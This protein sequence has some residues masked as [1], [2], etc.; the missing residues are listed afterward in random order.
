MSKLIFTGKQ[1]DAAIKK[2]QEGYADVSKVTAKPEQVR[3]GKRYVSKNKVLETGTL[4]DGSMVSNVTVPS[5][6]YLSRNETEY[7]VVFTPGGTVTRAGYKEKGDIPGAASH[8]VYIQAEEKTV[9]GTS[10]T[11]EV[12][13]SEG[14]L[15]KKVTIKKV[16]GEESGYLER[17]GMQGLACY[18]YT[19]AASSSTR[20]AYIPAGT[21]VDN[22]YLKA[23]VKTSDA[24]VVIFKI[25]G[26]TSSSYK[27]GTGYLIN[28]QSGLLNT[29]HI[30]LKPGT[31]YTIPANDTYY[32][33]GATIEYK[34]TGRLVITFNTDYRVFSRS[35]STSTAND[36]TMPLLFCFNSGYYIILIDSTQWTNGSK[37]YGSATTNIAGIYPSDSDIYVNSGST[38]RTF[39]Q[40]ETYMANVSC[41]LAA[42]SFSGSSLTSPL[43]LKVGKPSSMFYMIENARLP[44][45]VVAMDGDYVTWGA[46]DEATSYD[47]TATGNGTTVTKNTSALRYSM[48]SLVTND[49]TYEITVT[50]KKSGLISNPSEPITYTLER[51]LGTP[52]IHQEGEK[53]YIDEAITD[54]TTYYLYVNGTKIANLSYTASG[55]SLFSYCSDFRAYTIGVKAHKDGR[56]DS[57]L[58]NTISFTRLATP[59]LSYVGTVLSWQVI[60]GA[61]NYEVKMDGELVGVVSGISFD[62]ASLIGED[63][64]HT[65]SV[66]AIAQGNKFSTEVS[67]RIGTGGGTSFDDAIVINF[68]ASGDTLT[69]QE[70][71]TEFPEKYYRLQ[72]RES[73]YFYMYT[74]SSYD[75]YGTLYNADKVVLTT[76]DD[77]GTNYNF[78]IYYSLEAGQTYYLTARQY[79]R[80][81][82]LFTLKIDQTGPSG[83]GPIPPRPY[84]EIE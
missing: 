26:T 68:G 82:A 46:V 21:V 27:G 24:H 74:E 40:A 72:P 37:T 8:T 11:Y 4:D 47:V 30:E 60:S 16:T 66:K 1:I 81:Y 63:E 79:S 15:L 65:L 13:P 44:T 34:S 19:S 67:M 12:R 39:E 38:Q 9:T 29:G 17:L 41:V 75:T 5:N 10:Q 49:G 69:D 45:P 52:A 55:Y 43:T 31:T 84:P 77:G 56:T 58:S 62:F 78:S 23:G 83:S 73:G 64:R 6:P 42:C 70:V 22:I 50:A 80:N 61:E 3:R 57:P 18:F 76:N 36:Y 28:T 53:F 32:T 25:S 51:I 2:V 20:R 48:A 7:P 14:K 54:A 59:T 35:T 33:A 71:D